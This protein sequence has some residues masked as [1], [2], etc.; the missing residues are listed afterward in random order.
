MADP[1]PRDHPGHARQHAP[2]PDGLPRRPRR[3]PDPAQLHPADRRHRELQ[4]PLPD[5]LRRQRPGHQPARP[6]AA[7]RPLARRGD[8]ARGRADRRA[9][10]VG[11][12]ADGPS[13]DRRDHP[14][15]DR[16]QR[17]PRRPQ[18]ERH[19]HR[20]RRPVPRRARAACAIGSRSTSSSTA[21][22]SRPTSTTAARTCARS[23][24][25]RSS[26]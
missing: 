22:S 5:L 3:P 4:P 23:R 12:R 9:D 8:R 24:P 11:R 2:D 21:S 10:A 20:A 6:A 16:A 14:R 7:H 25:R 18:H 26:G 13:R 19:P 1:H 17:D 15:G